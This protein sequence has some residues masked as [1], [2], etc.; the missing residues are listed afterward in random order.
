MSLHQVTA[1]QDQLLKSAFSLLDCDG[2]GKL[3][4][5]EF[6][7][8]LRYFLELNYFHFFVLVGG[9]FALVLLFICASK[10]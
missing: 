1:E 7:T 8:L 6:R 9:C 4:E 10:L 5:D 2:D 3:G